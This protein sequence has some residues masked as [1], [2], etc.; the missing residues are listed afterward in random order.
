MMEGYSQ[1]MEEYRC[2]IFTSRLFQPKA[3]G[4][5]TVKGQ[6]WKSFRKRYQYAEF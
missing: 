2:L 3:G 4:T 6:K 1:T 5:Q